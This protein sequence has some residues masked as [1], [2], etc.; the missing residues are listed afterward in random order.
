MFGGFKKNIILRTINT[1]AVDRFRLSSA[2]TEETKKL[3]LS[4]RTAVIGEKKENSMLS[5]I[6]WNEM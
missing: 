4:S 1:A 6:A 5:Y 3:P 2:C